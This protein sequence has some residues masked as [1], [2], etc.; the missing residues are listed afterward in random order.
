LTTFCN[1]LAGIAK[2]NINQSHLG[3]GVEKPNPVS[4]PRH[5]LSSI[6]AAKFDPT[7]C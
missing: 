5:L 3:V 1:S 7:N 2:H 4:I 6:L